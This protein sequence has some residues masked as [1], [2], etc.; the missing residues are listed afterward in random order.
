MKALLFS[1]L[2]IQFLLIDAISQQF[3]QKTP[4]INK[5]YNQVEVSISQTEPIIEKSFD[6]E[7]NSFLIEFTDKNN[8]S[9][10][11]FSVEPY[12]SFKKLTHDEHF[13]G[14]KNLQ[15]QSNLIV[16][17]N[18]L[19]GIKFKSSH[20]DKLNFKLHLFS[21]NTIN[22]SSFGKR[23]ITPCEN[24][25]GIS[26]EIWREGL[27][28][29]LTVP[30]ESIVE[31]LVIHHTA[32][33]NEATNYTDVVRS[34]YLHH[35]QVNGWDDIG[36]NYLIAPNGVLYFGRDPQGINDQD[37]IKGAH[38]C[39][40]NSGTMGIALIGNFQDTIPSFEAITSLKNLI[41]WKLNK[42]GLNPL[43]SMLHPKNSGDA[44]NIG[45]V[46]GH[47]S[48][49]ST[50]CPGDQFNSILEQV[51]K[52]TYGMTQNC[53]A[54]INDK[55]VKNNF[56]IFPT[57]ATNE[58]NIELPQNGLTHSVSFLNTIGQVVLNVNLVNK[59]NKINIET[60]NSGVYS[61]IVKSK[62]GIKYNRLIV[63]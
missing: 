22:H 54:G 8:I 52:D 4:L 13:F 56:N 19:K 14:V 5:I 32:T 40:K 45:T 3:P 37:N 33:S 60:L 44:I 46:L 35:T 58:I 63:N 53:L 25:E 21:A 20:I 62:F 34:I 11:Q 43:D 7:F 9:E 61:V 16:L 6:F 48:G 47:R 18:Y 26:F 31:H 57:P 55:N 10:L 36:Y 12:T 39:G 30:T 50:Q 51:K 59:T 1:F 29:P 49:C 2:I 24:P 17:N 42:E 28:S 15:Y 41:S 23:N 27:N 38:F